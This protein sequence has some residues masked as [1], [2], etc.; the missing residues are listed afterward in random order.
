MAKN[1]VWHDDY[2]LL[3]L[4]IYLR[5]PVGVKPLYN[6][7]MVDLSLELHIPPE[8][9]QRRMEMIT[10]M[11]TPRLERFW[12]TYS[13]S[14]KRL[15]RAVHLLRE[16]KGF[17]AAEEFYQGVEVQETFERDFRPLAEDARFMPVMLIMIL[18]LYYQ[19]TPSTM[20]AATPEVVETAKLL[21]LKA[22]DVVEVL[23]VFQICD[24]YLERNEVT[25]SPL[26]A[27]CQ[28]V[29]Q[30]M[31]DKEPQDV[32]ALAEKLKEFFQS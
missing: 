15:E 22:S 29:W 6:R 17:G 21:R 13:K 18:D 27:P 32:H 12:N 16:M 28:Q 4:Q 30:R 26:L 1:L 23:G 31:V 24:P 3:L 14:P 9:L 19:L 10:R 25:L 8:S 20:V 11:D 7:A 2:W 5:K